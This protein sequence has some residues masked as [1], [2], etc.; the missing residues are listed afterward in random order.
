MSYPELVTFIEDNV[1]I[2]R[3][4][5]FAKVSKKYRILPAAEED[6]IRLFECSELVLEEMVSDTISW[7]LDKLVPVLSKFFSIYHLYE[8]PEQ[9]FQ[10]AELRRTH[11]YRS[12]QAHAKEFKTLFTGKDRPAILQLSYARAEAIERRKAKTNA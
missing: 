7:Y 10:N 6:C 12:L 2:Q 9:I 1:F 3:I 11:E 5:L 8:N 4:S